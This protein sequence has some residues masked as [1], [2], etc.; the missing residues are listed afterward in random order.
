MPKEQIPW[1]KGKKCPQISEA[2][3]GKTPTKGKHWKVSG[4]GRRNISEGMK[5]HLVSLATR[6]KIGK[7]E[8]GKTVTEEQKKNI[9][10]TH[11][12][13][14]RE[15][16][17]NWQGGIT[18][19]NTLIRNSLDYSLWRKAIFERDN[20]TCQ[21]C[22]K[23]GGKLIV[24]HINNFADFPEIRLAINNGIT[25]CKKCHNDFHKIY[26][27]K[28]NT[29]EQLEEFLDFGEKDADT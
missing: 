19:E 24:H 2:R 17:S 25:L 27:K 4:K 29:K 8:R 9:S 20:F 21:R 26:G 28:N 3:K 5:G 14:I 13:K 7:S 12:G 18:L 6:E 1:N 11:K 15:K 16:S 23:H 10:K 22:G